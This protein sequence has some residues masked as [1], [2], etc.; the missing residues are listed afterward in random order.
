MV[1]IHLNCVEKLA[2][3]SLLA[4]LFFALFSQIFP[5]FLFAI[6]SCKAL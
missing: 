6:Y 4:A 3:N 5:H 1:K 2:N